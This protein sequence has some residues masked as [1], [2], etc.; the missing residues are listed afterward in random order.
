MSDLVILIISS[1]QDM[2]MEGQET[3]R[4]HVDLFLRA[5]D[6]SKANLQSL[7]IALHKP[8]DACIDFLI[9]KPHTF[10]NTVT[11]VYHLC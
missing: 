1:S 5:I 7:T 10:T 3:I 9:R 4:L 2:G 6:D 8:I 11:L